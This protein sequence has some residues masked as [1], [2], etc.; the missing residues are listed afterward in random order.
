MAL[1]EAP[2]LAV[3]DAAGTWTAAELEECVELCERAD[4]DAA[5]WALGDWLLAKVPV[6]PV[7]GRKTGGHRKMRELAV[8]VG[9]ST[10]HLRGVRDTAYSWPPET[11]VPAA[12]FYIHDRFRD[13]GPERAAWRRERLLSTDRGP[14]GRVTEEALRRWRT[15]RQDDV[16]P[17]PTATPAP[18][19]M[20]GTKARP[21][22]PP[23]VLDLLQR[24]D[25][26]IEN[27][28]I[29]IVSDVLPTECRPS[30]DSLIAALNGVG[31]AL[32]QAK[33]I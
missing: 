29:L 17:T 23:A 7:A 33:L 5:R 12:R 14:R 30:L 2:P 16:T 1:A 10:V 24:C 6:R 4:A 11:R 19:S 20:L 9:W 25:R 15:A 18:R 3:V 8:R 31:E 26:L 32:A 27:T 22:V 13:G 28:G 21:D